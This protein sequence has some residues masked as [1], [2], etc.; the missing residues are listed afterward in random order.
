MVRESSR[1]VPCSQVSLPVRTRA[2]VPVLSLA[3]LGAGCA[4]QRSLIELQRR[5]D[6]IE[7][8]REE[9]RQKEQALRVRNADL[10]RDFEE[11]QRQIQV[12]EGAIEALPRTI[13]TPVTS[14]PQDQLSERYVQLVL[15]LSNRV[16]QLEERAGIAPTAPRPSPSPAPPPV[17]PPV[18]GP[19]LVPRA[20]G[21]APS[22]AAADAID[23][24]TAGL[25]VETD[26]RDERYR[27]ALRSYQQGKF[28]EAREELSRYLESEP[29]PDLADNA[30]FFIADSYFA[31]K[32]YEDALVA[33][34]RVIKEH[35]AGDKVPTALLK[36]A[37]CF[38]SLD[39]PLDARVILEKLIEQ[40]PDSDEARTAQAKLRTFPRR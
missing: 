39:Y 14:S 30:Q 6:R 10:A 4:S 35:P 28:A 20:P 26:D 16:L 18:A 17:R 36:Q 11:V 22:T 33:Y 9:L 5:V 23:P 7:G 19:T 38:L 37:E 40:H 31:E 21:T 29:T 27:V 2:L 1:A 12:I 34:E 3:L 32:R 13:S 8:D 15:N 25:V 24:P